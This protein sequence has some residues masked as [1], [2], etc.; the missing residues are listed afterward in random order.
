MK[1]SLTFSPFYF[2]RATLEVLKTAEQGCLHGCFDGPLTVA[3]LSV[4]SSNCSTVSSFVCQQQTWKFY[5][6]AKLPPK[7]LSFRSIDER[8]GRPLVS[9]RNRICRIFLRF[10]WPAWN[11]P[12]S[13]AHSRLD[14]TYSECT[15]LE[16]RLLSNLNSHLL[17]ILFCFVK[18]CFL[19]PV[20][21]FFSI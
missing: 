21:A 11:L 16:R 13:G 20:A 1:A 8:E 15:D 10:A 7:P 19:S 9:H 3:T 17:F 6:L 2:F 14:F 12:S 4:P 5:F 18:Y